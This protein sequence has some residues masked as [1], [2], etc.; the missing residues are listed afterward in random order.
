VRTPQ[1]A[2]EAVARTT[3]VPVSRIVEAGRPGNYRGAGEGERAEARRAAVVLLK[4][5]VKLNWSQVAAIMGVRH[6]QSIR[7]TALQADPELVARCRQ[8]LRRPA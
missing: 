2:L 6:A 5:S 7:L 1:E 8:E 3:G 4:E